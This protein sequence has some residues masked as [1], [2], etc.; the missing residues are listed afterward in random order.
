MDTSPVAQKVWITLCRWQGETRTKTVKEKFT[1]IHRILM[2]PL[3]EEK[4]ISTLLPF[5]L[6][7]VKGKL[8]VHDSQTPCCTFELLHAL[9]LPAAELTEWKIQGHISRRFRTMELQ[10]SCQDK[11]K[12]S[13]LSEIRF[14]C[15]PVYGNFPATVTQ[16]FILYFYKQE[17]IG[18]WKCSSLFSP[19]FF[20]HQNQLIIQLVFVHL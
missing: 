20:V 13:R 19:L 16:K 7:S 10:L 14:Q 18:K 2:V 3:N 12:H 9:T 5:Y 6:T 8:C 11:S 17:K 4:N 15:V 1:T